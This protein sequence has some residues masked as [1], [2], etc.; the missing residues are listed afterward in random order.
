MN[1]AQINHMIKMIKIVK[2]SKMLNNHIINKMIKS[3]KIKLKINIFRKTDNNRWM[4][5]IR[6]LVHKIFKWKIRK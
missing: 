2:T 3:K 6:E 1:W 5:I 4:E